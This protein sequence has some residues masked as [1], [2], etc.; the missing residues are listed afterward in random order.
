MIQMDYLPLI[1]DHTNLIVN[2]VLAVSRQP[3]P[4]LCLSLQPVGMSS[5]DQI[6]EITKP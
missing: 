3:L 1:R 5:V 4:T 6:E 2:Q